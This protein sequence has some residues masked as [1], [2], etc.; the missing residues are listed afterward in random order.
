[1]VSLDG[2]TLDCTTWDVALIVD[3]MLRIDGEDLVNGR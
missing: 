2:W 1:M 3:L